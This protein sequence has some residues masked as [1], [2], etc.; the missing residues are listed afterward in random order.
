MHPSSAYHDAASR[1]G[2]VLFKVAGVPWTVTPRSREFLASRLV[3]G[4]VAAALFLP[5]EDWSRRAW[6]GLLD[7][8]LILLSNVAHILGHT[9]SGLYAGSPMSENLITPTS[10]FTIY[11]DDPPN[12]AGRVHLARALGGPLANLVLGGTALAGCITF[13]GHPALFAAVLNLLLAVVLLLPLRGADGEVIWRELSRR[14]FAPH[15]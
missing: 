4:M 7:A 10:I 5:E 14:S 8:L 13:G 9:L 3:L 15:T 1:A 2:R 6:F 12:L 11:R